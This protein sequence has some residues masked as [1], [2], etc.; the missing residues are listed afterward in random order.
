MLCDIPADEPFADIFDADE[1]T[2]GAPVHGKILD[3]IEVLSGECLVC[4]EG[5][6]KEREPGAREKGVNVWQLR[7]RKRAEVCVPY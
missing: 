1:D 2:D 6:E 5:W 7:G 4:G 3:S